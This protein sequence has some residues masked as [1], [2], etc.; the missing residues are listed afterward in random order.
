M[1]RPFDEVRRFSRLEA[2]FVMLAGAC[3]LLSHSAEQQAE[4]CRNDAIEPR[5]MAAIDRSFQQACVRF[6]AET[7]LARWPTW[8]ADR[9]LLTMYSDRIQ[10]RAVRAAEV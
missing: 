7:D 4:T 6:E 8:D 1:S 2:R 3:L 10:R 5:T 9:R